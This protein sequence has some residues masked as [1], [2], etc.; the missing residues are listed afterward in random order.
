VASGPE[1]ELSYA[2]DPLD[3]LRSGIPGR[4][5]RR[6]SR[7]ERSTHEL[8]SGDEDICDPLLWAVLLAACAAR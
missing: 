1:L 5:T 8:L 3:V 2:S 7:A 6:R 4:S